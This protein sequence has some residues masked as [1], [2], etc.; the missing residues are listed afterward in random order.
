MW[1]ELDPE[2]REG[3]GELVGSSRPW[4]YVAH[5]AG[6]QISAWSRE[7]TTTASVPRSIC[8]RR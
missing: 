2:A 1:C 5:V 6:A 8:S 7:P 3:L 4:A